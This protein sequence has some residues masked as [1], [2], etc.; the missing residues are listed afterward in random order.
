MIKLYLKNWILN[1]FPYILL[2]LAI[3]SI[4]VILAGVSISV[5]T[6]IIT[7]TKIDGINVEAG[8]FSNLTKDIFDFYFSNPKEIV[9][10]VLNIDAI[11]DIVI[12]NLSITEEEANVY[13]K[14]MVIWNY[15]A[16]SII[17]LHIILAYL[18][19]NSLLRKKLC[20]RSIKRFIIVLIVK[21][22]IDLV[23]INSIA[24]LM[25]KYDVI[26][27]ISFIVSLILNTIL[28]LFLAYLSQHQKNDNIKVYN[29][30][31][32]KTIPLSLIMSILITSLAFIIYILLTYLIGVFALIIALPLLLYSFII[33]NLTPETY[34]I[35]YKKIAKS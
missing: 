27:I 6:S 15:I 1:I 24:L 18:I 25:T 5:S 13:S 14:T 21:R 3:I 20:P 4:G 34:V 30:I 35:N 22:I 7:N 2:I 10:H 19:T 16:M 28:T 9:K 12:D 33:T 26:A 8:K 23:V 32:H 29:V 17:I 11:K 31:N